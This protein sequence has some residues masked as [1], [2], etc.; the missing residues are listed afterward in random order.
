MRSKMHHYSLDTQQTYHVD[1]RQ[2]QSFGATHCKVFLLRYASNNTGKVISTVCF[3]FELEYTR[4]LKVTAIS[5]VSRNLRKR[6]SIYSM[7]CFSSDK[8]IDIIWRSRRWRSYFRNTANRYFNVYLSSQSFLHS[9]LTIWRVSGYL[10]LYDRGLNRIVLV[11]SSVTRDCRVLT[12][13][14][15]LAVKHDMAS[16]VCSS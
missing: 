9:D 5:P 7:T 8:I 14:W 6:T 15:K 10:L 11:K 12:T 2:F 16:L 4:G 1:N 3:V 13:I